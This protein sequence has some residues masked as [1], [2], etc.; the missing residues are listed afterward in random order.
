MTTLAAWHLRID[1]LPAMVP[2]GPSYPTCS[3]KGYDSL[4]AFDLEFIGSGQAR[5]FVAN[6]EN[7]KQ[8]CTKARKEKTEETQSLVAKRSV[9]SRHASFVNLPMK[10]GYYGLVGY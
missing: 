6:C 4:E 3:I 5:H 9:N 8:K 2:D 10:R 7:G 1:N